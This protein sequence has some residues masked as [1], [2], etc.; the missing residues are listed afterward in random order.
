MARVEHQVK[1]TF[2]NL[3]MITWSNLDQ[4]LG[5]LENVRVKK[6]GYSY[7]TPYSKWVR[8]FSPLLEQPPAGEGQDAARQIVNYLIGKVF[9]SNYY[10]RIINSK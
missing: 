9:I 8:R 2:P 7:R 10:L 1:V 6:A 4:Y 3:V 5:L